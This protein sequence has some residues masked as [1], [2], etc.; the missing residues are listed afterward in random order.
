VTGVVGGVAGGA[1]LQTEES[2]PI[3]QDFAP[4]DRLRLTL[5]TTDNGYFGSREATGIVLSHGADDQA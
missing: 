5:S 4:G 2:S 3:Q 1:G